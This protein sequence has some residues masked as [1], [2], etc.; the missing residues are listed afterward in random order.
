M[1]RSY[2]ID[3]H[4]EIEPENSLSCSL[5]GAN[6]QWFVSMSSRPLIG[7]SPYVLQ[8]KKGREMVATYRSYIRALESAGA[9]VILL[10][11]RVTL[12]PR[13]LKLLDGLLLTGGDDIHPKYFGRRVGDTK[14]VVSHDDRTRFELKLAKAFLRTKKPL[15]GICLGCQTLNVAKG[16]TL[17]LDIQSELPRTRDHREGEHTVSLTEHSLLRRIFRKSMIRVNSRHH[18]AIH[19]VG[20]GLCTTARST[21]GIVEAIEVPRARFALGV[22]WH[23]EE[24]ASRTESKKLF[25]AFVRSCAL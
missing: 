14:L 15:L 21:D 20:R 17:L 6:L 13:Y 16:G 3:I 12:I 19:K 9:D 7:I 10:T 18:Q 22:Q 23:P 4:G 24:I 2:N 1:I 5:E 8:N 25:R 11:P